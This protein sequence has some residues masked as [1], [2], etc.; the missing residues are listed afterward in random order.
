MT[1]YA[2]FRASDLGPV[3]DREADALDEIEEDED[4]MAEWAAENAAALVHLVTTPSHLP[5][6]L[7]RLAAKLRDSLYAAE[8]AELKNRMEP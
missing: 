4:F 5:T 1:M 3:D 7:V 6:E 8:R 2:P